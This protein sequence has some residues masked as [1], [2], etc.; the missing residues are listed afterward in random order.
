MVS[1]S[2]LKLKQN[3]EAEN[4]THGYPVSDLRLERSGGREGKELNIHPHTAV[5]P[6]TETEREI[7]G[8][9]Y[10]TGNKWW[11]KTKGMRKRS[12]EGREMGEKKENRDLT[13][14]FSY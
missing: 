13:P 1:W 5:V 12:A 11:K 10:E 8:K 2:V 9:V 4:I 14:K 3:K 6:V 7:E